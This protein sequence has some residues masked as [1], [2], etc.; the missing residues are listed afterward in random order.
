MNEQNKIIDSMR[1]GLIVSCQALEGEPMYSEIGGVMP[2][3]AIAAKQAG[4]IAIRANSARDVREIREKVNLPIIGLI[5]KSYPPFEQHI[6][7][8]MTEVDALV[9]AGADI[10]AFDCTLRKRP[11]GLTPIEFAD[12]IR[13][14]YPNVLLMADVSNLEEGINMDGSVVD[15]IGTT[16]SGYTS[17]CNGTDMT[18]PDFSLVEKLVE[19]CKTPIIAEGRIHYPRD[20]KKMLD[21][22]AHS[23][24]VG[25]AITRP[26]EIAKRF[27]DEIKEE[28]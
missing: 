10:I 25:G 11:D 20:A 7:V 6:T 13:R 26:Y 18:K 2:L 24:V 9:E 16:L 21:I 1:K 5:K 28:N 17:N 23:V 27:I 22:G 4:A 12:S 19:S 8:T 3:F 15:V 14:K